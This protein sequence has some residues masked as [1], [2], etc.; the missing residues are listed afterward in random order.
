[1]N[2][3]RFCF[4]IKPRLPGIMV[5]AGVISM[6]IGTVDAII[7]TAKNSEEVLDDHK[8]RMRLIAER[9]HAEWLRASIDPTG[10][11]TYSEEEKQRDTMSTYGHTVLRFGKVYLRS[12]IFIMGGMGLIFGGFGWKNAMYLNAVGTCGAIS[13]DFTN[14]RTRVRNDLGEEKDMEYMY[15]VKRETVVEN[16]V[17][18]ETGETEVVKKEVVTY[19]N[20]TIGLASCSFMFDEHNRNF[21]IRNPHGNGLFVKLA[22]ND[23]NDLLVIRGWVTLNEALIRCGEEPV[24]EGARL[25]WL[26]DPNDQNRSNRILIQVVN[27]QFLDEKREPD[28][29]APMTMLIFNCDGDIVAEIEEEGREKFG[30]GSIKRLSATA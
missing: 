23:L 6:V 17:N 8:A 13:Q 18:P 24:L 28:G 4:M 26:Y 3:S 25:G 30:W 19:D 14:Y 21:D 1:M 11:P 22:E 10:V 27:Q 12:S 7:Q 20:E 16:V 2:F 9:E 15:G 29:S 5:T